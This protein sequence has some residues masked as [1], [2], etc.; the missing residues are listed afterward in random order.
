MVWSFFFLCLMIK[1]ESLIKYMVSNHH[2][3]SGRNDSEFHPILL[4]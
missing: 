2:E 1:F 4:I 3:R